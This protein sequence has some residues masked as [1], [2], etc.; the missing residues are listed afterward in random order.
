PHARALGGVRERERRAAP[1]PRRRLPGDHRRGGGAAEGFVARGRPV[2]G[3]AAGGA[4][5][6]RRGGA[7]VELGAGGGRLA[8]AARVPRRLPLR[9]RRRP[10]G[11]ATGRA[12]TWR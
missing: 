5:V 11:D 8:V 10:A 9:A 1:Q 2:G 3:A 6:V 4:G 7:A 12:V